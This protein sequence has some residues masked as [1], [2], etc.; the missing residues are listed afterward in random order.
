MAGVMQQTYPEIESTC[1]V[2]SL[3]GLVKVEQNSFSEDI[4][5]VDSTFFRQFDFKLLEGSRE[6]PFPNPQSIII[7]K[8]IAKKFFGDANPLG[9]QVQ[10]DLGRDKVLFTVNGIAGNAPEESS[11]KYKVLIPYSNAR[12][13]FG[14]GAFTSWFNVQSSLCYVERK[15]GAADLERNSLQF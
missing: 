7:T 15:C 9:R 2:F 6:N 5:M 13:L 1:R 3:T 4:R 14:P 8:D 11:I 12:Y 10:I